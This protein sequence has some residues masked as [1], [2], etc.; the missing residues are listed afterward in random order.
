MD[1]LYIYGTGNYSLALTKALNHEGYSIKGYI[2]RDQ[3]NS[4]FQNK[5]VVTLEDVLNIE[6]FY[7]VVGSSFYD[8]ISQR[9]SSKGLIEYK[10]YCSGDFFMPESHLQTS[11]SQFGEDLLIESVFQKINFKSEGFFI[12][13]GA[14]HPYK[15]SNTYK[16]YQKGWRGINI[17][18]TP[19]KIELFNLLRPE[20]INIGVGISSK[21]SVQDLYIYN[22][23][24]FNTIDY[25]LVQKRIDELQLS[26]R[27]KQS[28]E[29]IPLNEII[30]E[31][32]NTKAIHL[33]TIDVEGHEMDV[34]QSYDWS[35]LQMPYVIA[36][37]IFTLDDSEVKSFLEE[38]GYVLL[39]KSIA[40]GVFV[41]KSLL[42][43]KK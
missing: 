16:F 21:K 35:S 10:N 41:L 38:Q 28:L 18:P 29:F 33:L 39:A 27:E 30:K 20:D 24:A 17:E 37:E 3:T 5:P 15:Y 19:Y 8:A 34:L 2:E 14:Y 13:V 12:D 4:E 36:I 40:T 11:F 43:V 31:H 22:E 1:N 26:Y 9:L 7:I 6:T 32:V 42:S 23:N 25:N